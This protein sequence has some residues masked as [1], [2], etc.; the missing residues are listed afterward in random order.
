MSI[1][2]NKYNFTILFNSYLC[3]IADS[4]KNVFKSFLKILQKNV[5]FPLKIR[6]Y[7]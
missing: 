6:I 7:R 1:N 4:S 5:H 2:T 3:I